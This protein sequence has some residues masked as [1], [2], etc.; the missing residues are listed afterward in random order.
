MVP[1]LGHAAHVRGDDEVAGH[2][3]S[4][5]AGDGHRGEVEREDDPVAD[6]DHVRHDDLFVSGGA[7]EQRDKE[8]KTGVDER[9]KA[10]KGR[11]RERCQ[12]AHP[13]R[14]DAPKEGKKTTSKRGV[15]YL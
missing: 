6:G 9:M 4:S 13:T 11:S 5:L 7:A 14:V 1:P 10:G 12:G 3:R 8:E 2:I 15:N